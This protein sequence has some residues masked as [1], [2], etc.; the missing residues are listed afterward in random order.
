M[1]DVYEL[2]KQKERFRGKHEAYVE[3]GAHIKTFGT[4]DLSALLTELEKKTKRDMDTIS[5]EIN[6]VLSQMT[7]P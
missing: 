1:K 3:L 4:Q 5:A 7:N 2:A 6:Q